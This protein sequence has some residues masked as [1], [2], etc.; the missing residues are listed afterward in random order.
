MKDEGI[1]LSLHTVYMQSVSLGSTVRD[2]DVTKVQG[3]HRKMDYR[4]CNMGYNN[5]LKRPLQCRVLLFT[6][7]ML[8]PCES[9]LAHF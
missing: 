8:F 5:L 6:Y 7:H 2:Y 4:N 9:G 3:P 1:K